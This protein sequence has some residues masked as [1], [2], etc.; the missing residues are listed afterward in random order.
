MLRRLV[1]GGV[2]TMVICRRYEANL[3]SRGE[4]GTLRRLRKKRAFQMEVL[5][6]IDHTLYLQ[7]ARAQAAPIL[8]EHMASLNGRV[9]KAA[10]R[11]PRG[12]Q[13]KVGRPSPG[14]ARQTVKDLGFSS[15]NIS[16]RSKAPELRAVAIYH[17]PFLGIA[18]VGRDN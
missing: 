2:D 3:I 18:R 7:V 8:T 6:G 1:V 13:R 10:A 14:P 15:G 16:T 4:K 17:G 12:R 9:M 5:S 11:D